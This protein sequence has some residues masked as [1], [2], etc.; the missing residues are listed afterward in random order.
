MS[1]SWLLSPH[2][3]T[4]LQGSEYFGSDSKKNISLTNWISNLS[5]FKRTGQIP[6]VGQVPKRCA[7]C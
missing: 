3:G 7:G 6:N 2:C 4:A 1:L 5:D